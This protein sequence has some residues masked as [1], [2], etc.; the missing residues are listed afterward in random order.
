M[1]TEQ[2]PSEP[3]APFDPYAAQSEEP[4]RVP[5][6]MRES[7]AE[8]VLTRSERFRLG[9]ARH[10]GKLLGGIAALVTLSFLAVVGTIGFGV[11]E[12]VRDNEPILPERRAAPGPVRPTDADGN[13]V[14]PWA[15]TPA[16]SFAAGKD[17][18]AL[19][20]AKAAAPFTAKQVADGLAK[21]R[22]ALVEGRVD[23]SMLLANDPK[24]FLGLIAPDNR[25]E[26][27]RDLADGA[28]LNYVTRVADEADPR[29]DN[30]D[31][32]RARGTV[33][34]RAT[35]DPDGIRVLEITTSFIWVYHFDLWRAQ[36]HPP[37]AELATVRDE[38]VWHVPHP[39]DV[40]SSS[41]GLWV[42]EAASTLYNADCAGIRRGFLALA[43][44]EPLRSRPSARPTGDVYDP[45]WRPGDG[46][47]C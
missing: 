40:R 2:R 36:E 16:E 43:P 20:P 21:V 17:A 30:A 8:R 41:R 33:T 28:A 27:R 4:I 31:T 47:S 29:L 1:S 18:I 23:R 13:S 38:V 25:D 19:P 22:Q 46:E 37:G 44:E 7:E 6:W 45:A 3:T 42:H 35:T 39:D 24:P 12:R 32:V 10:S 34:Y 14:S 5:S 26:V 11:Y 9:W 15:A